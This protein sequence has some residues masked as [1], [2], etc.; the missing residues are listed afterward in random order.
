MLP[1]DDLHL[2]FFHLEV[3]RDQADQFPIGL[4]L[5]RGRHDLG[6]EDKFSFTAQL[7]PFRFRGDPDRNNHLLILPD[8]RMK[9]QALQEEAGELGENFQ[10]GGSRT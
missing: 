7:G 4:S 9:P 3:I 8:L 10:P 6:P 5:V 1:P 2:A